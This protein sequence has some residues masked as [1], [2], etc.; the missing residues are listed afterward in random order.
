MARTAK[1][2]DEA[3]TEDKVTPNSLRNQAERWVLDQHRDEYY[4]KAEE[5]FAAHNMKFN[6]RPTPD[7][8]AAKEAAKDQEKADKA[9]AKLLEKHPKLADKLKPVQ[10]EGDLNLT[11]D[12]ASLSNTGAVGA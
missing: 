1:Q 9:L 5:L 4:A 2:K 6:R 3:V 12:V 11:A 8:K 10:G 7:E